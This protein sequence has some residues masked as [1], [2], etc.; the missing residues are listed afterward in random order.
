MFGKGNVCADE[1]EPTE[2]KKSNGGGMRTALVGSCP[3]VYELPFNLIKE[4]KNQIR[5]SFKV[6]A[7][8]RVKIS[9]MNCHNTFLKMTEWALHVW[10]EDEAQKGLSLM[11]WGGSYTSTVKGS[12]HAS[13]GLF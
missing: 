2:R 12:L 10:L 4:K 11:V 5:G 3:G 6:I 13:K 1:E 9:C 8:S 7:P